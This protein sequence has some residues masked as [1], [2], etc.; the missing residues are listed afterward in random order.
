MPVTRNHRPLALCA[1]I[2]ATGALAVT[3]CGGGTASSH[4]TDRTSG[5]VETAAFAEPT[6]DEW[7]AAANAICYRAEAQASS[8]YAS[9]GEDPDAATFEQVYRQDLLPLIQ[10]QIEDIAALEAPA[11]RQDDVDDF[12]TNAREAVAEVQQMD[13]IDLQ[14]EN[15]PF[16]LASIQ[17]RKLGLSCGDDEG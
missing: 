3:A 12:V 9:L 11:D 16:T 14:S 7:V 4:A 13:A 5:D 15:D 17:A 6:R 10:V 8:I 2:L 1:A